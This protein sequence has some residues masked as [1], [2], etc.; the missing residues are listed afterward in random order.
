VKID[1]KKELRMP[2]PSSLRPKDWVWR[3]RDWWD[4]RRNGPLV[5]HAD[6]APKESSGPR[7]LK[8]PI[9]RRP[10]ALRNS[11]Q[12]KMPRPV[13]DLYADL[14]DRHL[15]P[16]VAV[17]IVAIIAAPIL[18]NSKSDKQPGEVVTGAVSAGGGAGEPSFTVVPAARD[19]RSPAKRL[20]HRQALDPFRID[21]KAAEAET[22][23]KEATGNGESE[24]GG[25]GS[26]EIPASGGD[27]EIAITE[28]SSGGASPAES[29][30]VESSP[31]A[32]G[33]ST[34]SSTT[35]NVTVQNEVVDYTVDMEAGVVPGELSEKSEVEPMTKL[36]SAKN[37]VVLFVGLSQGN[38]RA[39]FLMTSKV[40]AYNGAVHC[41]V[42]K[43]ACQMVELKPGHAAVFSYGLGEAESRFKVVLKKI[44]PVVKTSKAAATKTVKTTTREHPARRGSAVGQARSFTK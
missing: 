3:I 20:G 42:D 1:W 44:E 4:A 32:T 2:R 5:S 14:R 23:G 9:L 41:A 36:P 27:N 35:A 43:D 38:K 37:P 13:T 21:T 22:E 18:L 15:L 24:A 33:E 17:L 34:S 7:A 39:L 8:G 28:S 31:P 6:R 40:T 19:L 26:T 29:A 10:K 11:P 12:V 16:L 25:A 30:P